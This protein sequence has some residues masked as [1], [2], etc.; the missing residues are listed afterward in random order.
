VVPGIYLCA[1]ASTLER[2]LVSARTCTFN[3]IMCFF[4]PHN[5]EYLYVPPDCYN[6]GWFF[7]RRQ[8]PIGL[9]KEISAVLYEVWTGSLYMVYRPQTKRWSRQGGGHVW[10][11][12][13]DFWPYVGLPECWWERQTVVLPSLPT[14]TYTHTQTHINTH[15]HTHTHRKPQSFRTGCINECIVEMLWGLVAATVHDLG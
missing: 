4:P 15:K 14:Y 5:I 12:A 13:G 3:T 6:T 8:A 10:R 7:P 1:P 11:R 2:L 9:F